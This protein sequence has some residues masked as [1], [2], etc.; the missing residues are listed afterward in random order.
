VQVG[1][2]KYDIPKGRKDGRRSKLEDTFDLPSSTFNASQLISNFGEH[3]FSVKE[4][5]S[6]SGKFK[7]CF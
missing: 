7:I 5:V 2:P 4:M 3:G 6:L 1:G